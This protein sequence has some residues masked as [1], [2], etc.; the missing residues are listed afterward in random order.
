MLDGCQAF[1]T[2]FC[3]TGEEDYMELERR[4]TFEIEDRQM[5]VM[6]LIVDDEMLENVESFTAAIT[7]LPGPFPVAVQRSQATVT[8]TDNDCELPRSWAPTQ[9]F[10]TCHA[11]N[12][13][14]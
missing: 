14:S 5:R 12:D 3:P 8:I 13:G 9:P 7:P 2:L 1:M 11:A 4:I 6:A 10:I